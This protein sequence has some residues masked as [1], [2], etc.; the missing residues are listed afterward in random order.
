MSTVRSFFSSNQETLIYNLGASTCITGFASSAIQDTHMIRENAR[1]GKDGICYLQLR[2][3]VLC[4]VRDTSNCLRGVAVWVNNHRRRCH[5]LVLRSANRGQYITRHLRLSPQFRELWQPESGHQPQFCGTRNNHR[6]WRDDCRFT[7]DPCYHE[8]GWWNVRRHCCHWKLRFTVLLFGFAMSALFCKCVSGQTDAWSNECQCLKPQ[9]FADSY[10]CAN[11][12]HHALRCKCSWLARNQRSC[13][14]FWLTT[15]YL[16]FR[17]WHAWR[18]RCV[19]LD[20]FLFR[21]G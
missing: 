7:N 3:I 19:W 4:T 12:T 20:Q 11:T 10:N 13:F 16:W 21:R 15:P 6:D 5:V 1:V 2:H 8:L 9:F 18:F 14:Q 17:N